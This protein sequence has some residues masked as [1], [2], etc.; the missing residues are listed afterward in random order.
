M[1]RVLVLLPLLAL[2]NCKKD[3]SPG[4]AKVTVD[5]SGFLPGC[6]QVNA[7]DEGSGKELS[8]TVAGK[9]ERT[10]GS[11][12]V[13]VIAPSGWGSTIQVE[14]RAFEQTCEAASPVVTRSTS[15]TLTPGTP[16]PVALSLQATDGDGDGYVSVLTGGTDCNDTN[17]DIRPGATERCN[18]VDDN[19]NGQSDTVELRLGQSCTEGQGCEGVRA[20]GGNGE[21]LCNMPLAAYAYPDVDQDGHGDRNAAPVAFC[22]GI[23]QGYV[24]SPA[25]DCNDN[26]ASIRPGATE[27]CNG[28]D[29]NCNDQIDET[30]PDLGTACTADAQ[31]AGVY[32]CDASGIATTCQAAATP[33]DWFLDG[34]GDTFGD[35][36]AVSSCV[37]PGASYVEVGGDCNDGN[38]FTY[39][40]APELCDGLDN[41]CDGNAEGPEV[42]PSGGASWAA[43]TVGASDQEWRSIF[44]EAPGDVSVSGNQGGT[45]ILK[46][47]SS[48]F[49]TNATNCGDNNRG[50]NA[51]WADM[52]NLG[53]LYL[54]SSGGSLSFLDRSEN[55]CTETNTIGR[56][57][58]GL[59]GFR[60]E[61]TLEIHGVTENSGT[62][63]QGLTFKWTGGSSSSALS[64]GPA[65][66]A[67]LFD[68]HGRS[69]AVMFAVGGLD[70]GGN[71]GRIHRFNPSS[72]QW[73]SESVEAAISG[74]GRLRG[75]WVVND[76]LAF[77]VGERMNS[78]NT[79]L[80]WD[81]ST[82]SR[83]SS[84][85]NTQSETLTS[86]IAF[87]SK[88]VYVTAYNGRI[89]R[90]DG[91]GW[92]IVFENTS[93]RFNDIAGTSPADLW[94]AGNAGQ[95]L[96]WPQ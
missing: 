33:T 39:P 42:C 37:S 20:C 64:F 1:R 76:K 7:R 69:R 71:R 17:P 87:G 14:A 15:V 86:V 2:A 32:V 58:K 43:R 50:W 41:N 63:G 44:T 36:T 57:V 28:V 83:M 21:V 66:V 51:V 59:V 94:V 85:P 31:C 80:Q 96:H 73:Q 26:N 88:S 45:A 47:P 54:G 23:P 74:M 24:V 52:A 16:V 35:G 19:C 75:V 49:Q 4:A 56:W 29:D 34:D 62:G 6:V 48:T 53:R 95:I 68:I 78:A 55:A 8:T 72:G 18:D 93:L 40:G 70:N 9:G 3:E 10:G 38:P 13:A 81:G 5:Y 12:T 79:V 30:F 60:H 77:A 89:Y 82:W 61:G 90:Y 22:S 46:P 65:A 67:P 84:F 27:L 91:T 25:D 92:Q 11:L